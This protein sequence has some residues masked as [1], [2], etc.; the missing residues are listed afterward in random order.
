MIFGMFLLSFTGMACLGLSND[1]LLIACYI[2]RYAYAI[3]GLVSFT[4]G[5]LFIVCAWLEPKKK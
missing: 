2:R 1:G 5:F 4:L 3:P